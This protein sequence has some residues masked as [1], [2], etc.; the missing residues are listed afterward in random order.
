[1]KQQVFNYKRIYHT[2]TSIIF[3][4]LALLVPQ[5]ATGT[6]FTTPVALTGATV[7]PAPGE[8]LENATVI[9][10]AG[11]I[12]KVGIGLSIP[13]EAEVLDM[14]GL[15]VYPGFIDAATHVGISEKVP[16]AATLARLL[17]KEQET[18]QGPRTS[19]QLANR[20]GV[21]PHLSVSDLYTPDKK[22]LE[23]YRKS[24]FTT[25]LITPHPS[26][27]GGQGALVQLSDAPMRQT[28][29]EDG[30]TQIIA[31]SG[32]SESPSHYKYAYPSSR[33]GVTAQIRQTF[34]DAEWYLKQSDLAARNPKQ[35]MRPPTDPVLE[36][37]GLLLDGEQA[38]LIVANDADEIHHALD[39]A[40]ELD[41]RLIIL[42]GTEA[43]KVTDRL[44][45]SGTAVIAS[46]DWKKKPELAPKAKE[47]S[48]DEAKEE[49]EEEVE[50]TP[51]ESKETEIVPAL[52]LTRSWEKKWEDDFFE[53][54]SLRREKIRLWEEQVNNVRVLLEAG[55]PVALSGAGTSPDKLLTKLRDALELELSPDQMLAVLTTNPAD[56]FGMQEQVGTIS[57]GALANLT[58]T[59]QPL[60]KKKAKVRYVFI[61]GERFDIDAGKAEDKKEKDKKNNKDE[62]KN[63][64]DTDS[65]AENDDAD[66]SDDVTVEE[67]KDDDAAEEEKKEDKEPEDIHPWLTESEADRKP[68]LLTDGNVM[69]RNATVLTVTNGTLEN[70][71]VLV[72]DGTIKKIGQDLKLPKNT[73]EID[74]QGYWLMPGIVDPHGH[75]AGRTLNEGTQSVTPE[76]QMADVI[77]HQDVRIQRALA[78]GATTMHLMHGS[79]N[80]IGGQNVVIKL[81][82]GKSPAE[83]TDSRGPRLVK[84]A[85]GE[86]VTWKNWDGP[87]KRFPSSRMGVESVFRQ[88]FNDALEYQ[89][90]WD[91]FKKNGRNATQVPR[92]DLRLE[93]LNDIIAGDIWVHSHG[94]RSDELLRLLAV[95]EDYGFRIAC[96]QHVLEGYRILPEMLRHG[97][98]GSTFADFWAY[99]VEAYQAIPHNATMMMRAGIVSSINSD[100]ADVIRRLNTE[101]AKSMRFGGLS[102]NEALRLITINPAI[103]LGLDE[104]VGSIEVGK[105]ADFAVYTR[106][107]LDTF[108]RN[109][110][111][112][113]DGE[114]YFQHLD[115]DLE[116]PAQK[117]DSTWTP[118]A[119][120]GLL[121]I[122]ENNEGRY[123]V[124]GATVHPVSAESVENASVIIQDGKITKW[125]SGISIPKNTTVV[126]AAGLHIYPGLINAAGDMG[127]ME[128][129]SVKATRDASELAKFQPANRSLSAV[130]PYSEHIRISRAEGITTVATLPRGGVISGQ[131]ALIQLDGWTM[132]EM[133]REDALGMMISLPSLPNE[134][135]AEKK[136]EQLTKHEKSIQEIEAFIIKAQHYARVQALGEDVP[137]RNRHKDV[138]LEAMIPYVEGRK[139][140]LF[141]AN[142]Y[143]GILEALRFAKTFDLQ[144]IILGGRDAWKCSTQLAE[145][146]VPVIITT[147]FGMPTNDE[148]YD[149]V[150]GNAGRLEDAGV[151]FC[152]AG[153]YAE[154]LKE[155]PLYAGMAVAHGLSEE[156]ALRSITLSAAEIL[157]VADSIG[158]IDKGKIADIIITT[159]HPS[160]A[161]TRTVGSF[162]GGRPVDLTSQH[163]RNYEKFMARPAP[164]LDDAPVLRGPPPMRVDTEATLFD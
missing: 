153:T 20:N 154:E 27:F 28:I 142:S 160:Q 5:A 150:Y 133:L 96:L 141:R 35:A 77:N 118:T 55:V 139:P 76:V 92:H 68:P 38:L 49:T 121:D 70:T 56:I 164:E 65:D 25:A 91:N 97:V 30:L 62:D 58:V 129:A 105:D 22:K 149:A 54:L 72:K 29:L 45:D 19:M 137:L 81:K 124:V 151:R 106:H 107:P 119:P 132:P 103:Q 112:L 135:N 146:D 147:V 143:K 144:P 44:L 34:L 98:S 71:D 123:A 127:M 156:G 9:I 64:G 162:I 63:E 4:S 108:S 90:T 136:G 86:N 126:D 131:G 161:S 46:L 159:G 82:Y 78:G 87:I 59:T 110:L 66:V 6:E 125:G 93:A 13:P 57:P 84:F 145:A 36:T 163:D 117:S 33:M 26:I 50:E 73:M 43:W 15:W 120:R 80:T 11:R 102:S 41:Q 104:Y 157:G 134:L 31:L 14:A 115:L 85:L 7:I 155:L 79:A 109:V 1:M 75:L 60:E 74:L 152:I 32:V 48:E 95:A 8:V 21:W 16:D 94:Y 47:E 42:G 130:H 51:V 138:Q 140:V 12:V 18:R 101:A 114:V 83:M 116:A 67:K 100:S 37:M 148:Q 3:L 53:P 128:I 2:L 111:T 17:D 52:A 10:D 88:S 89:S 158:S 122:A 39:L 113:I 23:A 99:K 40:K 24:G 61:D 69:L